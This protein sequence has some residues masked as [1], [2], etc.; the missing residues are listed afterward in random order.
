VITV[1][2]LAGVGALAAQAANSAPDQRK[3]AL[4]ASQSPA[5]APSAAGQSLPP[6]PPPPP[7]VPAKSG[8]GKRVVYSLSKSWVWLVDV[9]EKVLKD[10]PVVAGTVSAEAGRFRVS[11]KQEGPMRGSDGL[12]IKHSV[13]FATSPAGLPIGFAGTETPLDQIAPPPSAAS[14]KPSGS[15]KPTSAPPSGNKAK[16]GG[17]RE[18]AESGKAL[19]E[20]VQIGDWVIVVA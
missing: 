2:A 11:T 12:T 15:K 16:S 14:P 13:K 18:A 3:A 19:Y 1:L 10:F 20:F 6:A 17:V 8:T 9:D 5:P 4:S 7:A